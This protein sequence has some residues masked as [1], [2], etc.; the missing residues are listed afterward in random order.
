MLPYVYLNGEPF[1]LYAVMAIFGIIFVLIIGLVKRKTFGLRKRD[2]FRLVA[3]ATLGALMGGKL[4]SVIGN[5]I[6][7]SGAPDFWTAARWAQIL[8]AGQVFYGGLLGAVGMAVLWAKIGRIDLKNMF[9]LAAYVGFAFQSFGRIGCYCAGCCYGITLADGS[10][11]PVQL[12]EA[13]FCFVMLLVF[14]I[15]KPERRWPTLPLFPVYVIIYSV[16]RFF[17]EFLRGDARRGHFWIFSTS[18]WIAMVLIAVAILWLKKSKF[19]CRLGKDKL[20]PAQRPTQ[21]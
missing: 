6:R 12:V 18:Q 10:H 1:P 19:T 7:F 13:G 4:F 16:G 14:L 9:N 8:N 5:V 3:C 21:E 11:F 2:I 17:L 15:I 20:L